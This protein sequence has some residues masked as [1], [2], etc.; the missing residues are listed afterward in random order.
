MRLAVVTGLSGGTAY[1]VTEQLPWA[2]QTVALLTAVL[3]VQVSLH[4]TVVTAAQRLAATLM[5]V[6]VGFALFS[7]VGENAA[8]V[9]LTVVASILLGRL[10]RLGDEALTVPVT[11]LLVLTLSPPGAEFGYSVEQRLAGT[12][13]G[14]AIAVVFSFFARKGTPE[15]VATERLADIENRLRELLLDVAELL[16]RT[17]L[18]TLPVA[19]SVYDQ[20]QQLVDDVHALEPQIA[21]AEGY[22]RWSPLASRDQAEALRHHWAQLRHAALQA[23]GMARAAIEA[24]EAGVDLPEEVVDVVAAVSE[25][26]TESEDPDVTELRRQAAEAVKD[27]DSTQPLI[28][29]ASLLAHADRIDAVGNEARTDDPA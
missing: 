22:A 2:D 29:S 16:R 8:T 15:S 10:A 5:G 24:V 1:F 14:G 12:V 3:V 18:D 27:L 20:A 28:L 23:R 25:T 26:F 13:I 7:I 21:E 4:A 6:A 17:D 11:S 9:A 19:N